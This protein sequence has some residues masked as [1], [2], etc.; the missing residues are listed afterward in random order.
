MST[1]EKQKSKQPIT[2]S[3]P[4]F[5]NG[6]DLQFFLKFIKTSIKN[7]NEGDIIVY[8][9]PKSFLRNRLFHEMKKD[10]DFR[11]INVDEC[12]RHF[13]NVSSTFIYFVAEKN[14][15]ADKNKSC[16]YITNE[17][18]MIVDLSKINFDLSNTQNILHRNAINIINKIYKN[19]MKKAKGVGDTL[20]KKSKNIFSLNK[21]SEFKYPAFLSSKSDRR[22]VF[23]ASPAKGYGI[24]KLCV[25]EILEPK[26]SKYFCEFNKNKSVGRYAHYFEC[27]KQQAEII[28]EFY[29]SSYYIYI[30]HFLRKGRYAFVDLPRFNWNNNA[31]LEK[32]FD[33]YFLTEGILTQDEIDEINDFSSNNKI[34]TS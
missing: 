17:V 26:K 3:N 14:T 27:N 4:P 12:G 13:P 33:D 9:C 34:V 8:I 30:N 11:V 24:E 28:L 16:K 10:F 5:Q 25:A 20:D 32:N 19:K 21:D 29:N 7:S 23:S 31:L 6:K 2:L 15:S 1:L 18:N 22:E